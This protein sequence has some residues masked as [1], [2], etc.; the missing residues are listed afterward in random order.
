MNNDF[1][2]VYEIGT[3]NNLGDAKPLRAYALLEVGL[4]NNSNAKY[5]IEKETEQR[6][7]VKF[8]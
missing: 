5:G 4:Y 3:Q 2:F 1:A 8:N 6:T 7:A